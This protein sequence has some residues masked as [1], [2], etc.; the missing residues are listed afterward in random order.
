MKY[1]R[2]VDI[3]WICVLCANRSLSLSSTSFY[4]QKQRYSSGRK[5]YLANTLVCIWKVMSFFNVVHFHWT[6]LT[7]LTPRLSSNTKRWHVYHRS[8]LVIHGSVSVHPRQ[9]TWWRSQK[10]KAGLS[11]LFA[12]AVVKVSGF[13][14]SYMT[15]FQ[16]GW[17]FTAEDFSSW[18]CEWPF[19]WMGQLLY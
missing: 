16:T 8:L 3:K 13:R 4:F 14:T 19:V 5:L 9:R 6:W 1:R 18:Q 12:S 15:N 11:V 7:P 17:D 10:S 2:Q